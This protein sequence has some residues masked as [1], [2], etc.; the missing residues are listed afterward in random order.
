[1]GQLC[2]LEKHSAYQKSAKVK[3]KPVQEKVAG[4]EE[5]KEEVGVG[6][7]LLNLL[8][9]LVQASQAGPGSRSSESHREQS[10]SL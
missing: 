6:V 8:D 3:E 9:L 2:S 10:R 4:A 5:R 7:I 1:M